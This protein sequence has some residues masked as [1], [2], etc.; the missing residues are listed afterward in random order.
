M[1][2]ILLL[3]ESR[4]AYKLVI[5]FLGVGFLMVIISLV[6]LY[7][8]KPNLRWFFLVLFIFFVVSIIAASVKYI[9]EGGW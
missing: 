9:T 4:S 3:E 6:D 1:L 8:T 7:I 5:F 2:I